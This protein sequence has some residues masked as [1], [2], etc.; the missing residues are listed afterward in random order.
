MNILDNTINVEDNYK[1]LRKNVYEFGFPRN[2]KQH[3]LRTVIDW[4]VIPHFE[5][6]YDYPGNEE[7]KEYFKASIIC[8]EYNDMVLDLEPNNGIVLVNLLF[9]AEHWE[10]F[11]YEVQSLGIMG[12]V[13][14]FTY[15]FEFT[16]DSEYKCYSNFQILPNTY[17]NL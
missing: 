1:D 4:S 8:K 12:I 16:D 2:T 13:K 15:I 7:I 9:F 5:F 3:I 11:V 14:D 10:E 6:F 17:I